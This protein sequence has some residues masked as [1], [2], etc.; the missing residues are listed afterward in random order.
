MLDLRCYGPRQRSEHEA[1]SIAV[2]RNLC[3]LS[4][5]DRFTAAGTFTSF[6]CRSCRGLDRGRAGPMVTL[7][8]YLSVARA[9]RHP[10][11]R[12]ACCCCFVAFS[13]ASRNRSA[14]S[15]AEGGADRADPRLVRLIDRL[16]TKAAAPAVTLLVPISAAWPRKE[17]SVHGSHER[18]SSRASIAFPKNGVSIRSTGLEVGSWLAPRN[19]NH[20]S[21]QR[22][23]AA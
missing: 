6:I 10:P 21:Q 18:G 14:R 23:Q 13:A 20:R 12:A 17:S 8:R 1:Q 15:S 3:A 11:S 22:V 19:A 9:R 7:R 2:D 4:F 5:F 16:S